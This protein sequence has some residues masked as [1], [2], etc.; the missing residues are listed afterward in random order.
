MVKLKKQAPPDTLGNLRGRLRMLHTA[1]R[2]NAQSA[3]DPSAALSKEL[4]RFAPRINQIQKRLA[5]ISAPPLSAP[6]LSAP[7]L[8]APPKKNP[9]V[10]T[11][12]TDSIEDLVAMLDAL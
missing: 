12:E 2:Q 9:K 10:S 4:K 3:E 1:A 7:P 5:K 6:P 11:V 8:S